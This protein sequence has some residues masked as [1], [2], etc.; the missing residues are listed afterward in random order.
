MNEKSVR[1]SWGLLLIGA[2]KFIC[3]LLLVGLG[4]GLFRHLDRD[5]VE[6]VDHLARALRIDP[7]N[8]YVHGAIARVSGIRPDQLRA[9]GIGTFLYALMYL[10]EG[11]GLLLRKRWGEYFTVLATGFFIPLEVYEV[12]RRVTALRLGILIINVAIVIYL[13]IQ[14]LKG[15]AED[16]AK[17]TR[18]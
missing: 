2:F 4:I 7:D 17:A 13:I 8:H 11:T 10:V 15:R 12:I 5:P 16:K 9:I 14:V 6:W 18:S 1:N 3:G